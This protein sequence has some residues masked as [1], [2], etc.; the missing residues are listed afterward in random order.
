MESFKVFISST[1][2]DLKAERAAG[3]TVLR[4]SELPVIEM[5]NW[6]ALRADATDV[7]IDAVNRCDIFIG[8]YAFR[9]GF[10]PPGA[11]TSITEQE[12]EEARR[13]GKRCLC[14]FA[15]EGGTSVPTDPALI[16]PETNRKI[17]TD[18]K[19]RIELELVRG[20]FTSPD[21]L[22]TKVT[23]DISRLERGYLPG[24]TRRDLLKR[25]R[26]G[27]IDAR[28]QLVRGALSGHVN[29][30]RS[31]LLN[32]WGR[33][34]KDIAWHDIVRG[35]LSLINER[36][37][38]LPELSEL[39]ARA[40]ELWKKLTPLDDATELSNYHTILS[41]LDRTIT[42]SDVTNTSDLVRKF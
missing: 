22:A 39:A 26:T 30:L 33:F 17:L 13:Q 29:L 15:D 1:S 5:G 23:L 4:K 10:I 12:Y 41:D 11:A 35:S 8:I 25:W 14:Y 40:G 38:E 19:Q 16:E 20:R 21:D 32:W 9:Y 42:D 34:V 7:S 18:F 31:P 28:N 6:D 2:L 36:A 27:G 24:Y 37:N 3:A